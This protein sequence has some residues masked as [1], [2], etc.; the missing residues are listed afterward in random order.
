MKQHNKPTHTK[1]AFS[2]NKPTM[3]PKIALAARKLSLTASSP[4]IRRS[5]TSGYASRKK[6]STTRL[7]VIMPRKKITSKPKNDMTKFLDSSGDG[8][9][10][11]GIDTAIM[12]NR[13]M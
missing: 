3:P 11:L 4:D 13:K 6:N 5:A 12:P 7:M 10:P 1:S 8:F 2:S 9:P